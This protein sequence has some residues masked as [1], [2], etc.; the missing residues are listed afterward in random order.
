MLAEHCFAAQ[1]FHPVPPARSIGSAHHHRRPRG[2]SWHCSA[3]RVQRSRRH[4]SIVHTDRLAV[5]NDTVGAWRSHAQ[6]PGTPPCSR[7]SRPARRA[8]SMT[9]AEPVETQDPVTKLDAQAALDRLLGVLRCAA[10][11]G[12][13]RHGFSASARSSSLSRDAARASLVLFQWCLH[14][15][16]FL[17]KLHQVHPGTQRSSSMCADCGLPVAHRAAKTPVPAHVLLPMRASHPHVQAHIRAGRPGVTTI[18][19]VDKHRIHAPVRRYLDLHRHSRHSPSTTVRCRTRG[20]RSLL[21]RGSP[22]DVVDDLHQVP[23]FIASRLRA[24]AITEG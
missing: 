9:L 2:R 23:H 1:H 13:R 18:A 7:A 16:E 14:R 19:P 12:A 21:Q 3:V 11:L 4:V 20:C 6:L 24:Q 17:R 8:A 10:P 5:C 15:A 22:I